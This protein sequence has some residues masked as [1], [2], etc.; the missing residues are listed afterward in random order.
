[1]QKPRAPC[2]WLALALA[3]AGL[4]GAAAA[5]EPAQD[6]GGWLQLVGEGSLKFVDPRLARGRLW[7][8]G[9]TS[10]DDDWNHWYQGTL[11]AAFGYS[12]SEHATLW[13]GYTWAPTQNLGKASVQEQD[14]WPALRYVWPTDCG[15]FTY[16]IMFEAN[17]L[18]GNH[19]EVRFRPRQLF[20]FAHAL[21]V[22]PR[23]SLVAWDEVFVRVNT[24]PAGG[25][26][27]FDQNRAF[28][29]IGWTF[30]PNV[31]AEFGYL[32]QYIDDA[33]H[34]NSTLHHLILG[35]VAVNF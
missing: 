3:G 21:A 26:S 35:S 19:G 11:R 14:A 18:P 7:L 20:R 15:A 32:N 22:E 28:G 25:Q 16:R 34:V 24:T 23:L 27:G 6:A 1:M 30:N 33:K 9:I 2:R 5:D 31:R 4:V 10:W 8:E 29:G 12:L 13:A 17:F